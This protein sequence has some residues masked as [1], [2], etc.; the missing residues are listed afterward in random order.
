MYANEYT[1]EAAEALSAEGKPILG[2][3][4]EYLD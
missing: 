4:F 1:E 3:R 2:S